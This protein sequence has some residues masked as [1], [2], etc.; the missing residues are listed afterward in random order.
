M[1]AMAPTFFAL[2]MS[3]DIDMTEPHNVFMLRVLFLGSTLLQLLAGVIVWLK[4]RS[5]NDQRP[6]T[7]PA[8]AAGGQPTVTTVRVFDEGEVRKYLQGI[9][10]NTALMAFF[11]LK[12]EAS[13]PVYF[14]IFLGLFRVWDW[15]Q[16]R[17]NVL[18]ES[19]AEYP[20]LKRPFP[21]PPNPFAS[22]MGMF[23]PP[24]EEAPAA[25]AVEGG[26]RVELVEDEQPAESKKTK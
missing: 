1:Q 6:V 2:Y 3:R 24:A 18:G 11:H 17:L 10:T 19:E 25:A 4:V 5:A 13:V 23:N 7:L 9:V 26:P 8:A 22:L 12:L 21:Q 16:F 14:Q 20:V 15:E